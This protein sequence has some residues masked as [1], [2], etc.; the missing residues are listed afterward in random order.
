M[1][2]LISP[3][4]ELAEFGELYQKRK[5]GDDT[6][7]RMREFPENTYDVCTERWL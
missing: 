4:S 6:G 5:G 2:A 7:L 1:Q 3:L